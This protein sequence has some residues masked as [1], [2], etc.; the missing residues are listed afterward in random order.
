MSETS[1]TASFQT[2]AIRHEGP[3]AVV[4]LNRPE[5]MNAADAVMHRELAQIWDVI[6]ADTTVRAVVLT[7]AGRAF[8]AGGDFPR[9]VATQRDQDIQDEVFAEA[10]RMVGSMVDLPQPLIAAVNGPAVG[11]GASL[12]TLCDMAI[13]AESAFIADP[14]LGVGL[15]PGDGA[16][17]LWPLTIGL[18]RAK[19]YVFTGARIPATTARE[20][21][22]V[23]S[24]V[25]AEEVVPAAV[26]LAQRLA[27][28]PARALQD[29]KRLLNTHVTRV[30]TGLLDQALHAERASVNS[31]E[32]AELTQRLIEKTRP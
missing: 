16:A 32:H 15:V 21:G 3:V 1:T 4:T 20:L 27:E 11:L 17:L 2:I 7:G 26:E 6:A 19:E 9:M 18:M 31:A 29:T 23:N 5:A 10:R 25:P 12:V 14:H 28:V 22:L 30:L 8:S 24:V 13:A